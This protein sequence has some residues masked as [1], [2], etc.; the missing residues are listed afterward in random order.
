[1]ERI[2]D[3]QNNPQANNSWKPVLITNVF[4]TLLWILFPLLFFINGNGDIYIG[5]I[6]LAQ[7]IYIALFFTA[8]C[9]VLINIL[10]TLI[11]LLFSKNYWKR[12]LLMVGFGFILFAFTILFAFIVDR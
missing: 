2:L 3:R 1:M 6:P 4:L 7:K 9:T 11:S 12:W 8:I 10:L 5:G